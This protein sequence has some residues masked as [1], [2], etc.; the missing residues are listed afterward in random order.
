M[1]NI[2]MQWVKEQLTEARVKKPVGNAIMSLIETWKSAEVTDAAAPQVIE[3]FSKLAL[4]HVAVVKEEKDVTWVPVTPGQI[5][6]ADEVRVRLDAFT[7]ELG[8]IHN[9]R[10]GRVVAVRYGDV[11]IK[12]TDGRKPVL[13]GAHY[14]PQHLEKR[15]QS[16]KTSTVKLTVYG[17]TY[18]ELS[19]AAENSLINFLQVDLDDLDKYAQYELLITENLDM[20]SDSA[21]VADVVARIKR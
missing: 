16:M 4:G 8:T 12:T 2:D 17:D 20:G 9:G 11:I 18:S 13:D 7:G 5:K 1:P 3:L 6:V 15:I 19:E 14:P 10:I 21:Y